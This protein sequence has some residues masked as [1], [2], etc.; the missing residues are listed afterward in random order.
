MYIVYFLIN[1][2]IL[3]ENLYAPTTQ[4]LEKYQD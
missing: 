4:S 1:Q 3:L 2:A